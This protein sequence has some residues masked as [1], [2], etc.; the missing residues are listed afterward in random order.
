ML[1]GQE[2]GPLLAAMTG[3]PVAIAHVVAHWDELL[4][5]ATSIRTVTASA[6]LRRLST[7]PRQ[8]GMAIALRELGRLERSI[9]KP[10]SSEELSVQL[11]SIC[12]LEIAVADK[13]LGAAGGAEPPPVV[14]DSA[15]D[16]AV[17]FWLTLL[18]RAVT[19]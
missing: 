13:P 17:A 11:I 6:M 14:A 2:A 5:F 16:G 18:S 7:Y 10:V 8:N 12:V 1:P 19:V 3:N 4:R 9:L 15:V